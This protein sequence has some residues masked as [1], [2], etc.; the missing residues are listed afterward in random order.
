MVREVDHRLRSPVSPVDRWKQDE[1]RR[2][3]YGERVYEH[4]RRY[5]HSPSELIIGIVQPPDANTTS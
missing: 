3:Y 5:R 4:A 2:N 1:N